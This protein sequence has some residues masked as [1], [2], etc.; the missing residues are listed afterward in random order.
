MPRYNAYL[1]R[2][3]HAGPPGSSRWAARLEHLPQGNSLLFTERS[4]LLAYIEEL[5]DADTQGTSPASIASR[6]TD[7]RQR[8]E[9]NLPEL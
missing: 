9:E 1:L 3:W 4:A 5:A 8:E 2:V 6:I 7:P